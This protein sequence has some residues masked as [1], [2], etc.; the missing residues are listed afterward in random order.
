MDRIQWEL[1]WLS[2][3]SLHFDCCSNE[4]VKKKKISLQTPALMGIKRNGRGASPPWPSTT[5]D[6]LLHSNIQHTRLVSAQRLWGPPPIPACMSCC[7][8][9][10]AKGS[11]VTQGKLRDAQGCRKPILSLGVSSILNHICKYELQDIK[12]QKWPHLLPAHGYQWG[13]QAEQL[14]EPRYQQ[15]H[16]SRTERCETAT[17]ELLQKPTEEKEYYFMFIKM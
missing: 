7:Q 13:S 6:P 4:S 17:Y 1:H 12:I 3:S 16:T 15:G 2:R 9:R 14:L 11:G 10:D 8:T 5:R